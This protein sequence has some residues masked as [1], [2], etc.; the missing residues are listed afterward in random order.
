MD[1]KSNYSKIKTELPLDNLSM[2]DQSKIPVT[3]SKMNLV[4]TLPYSSVSSK[5]HKTNALNCQ[6]FH[7]PISQPIKYFNSNNSGE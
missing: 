5:F 1:K 6:V 2:A 3:Y 7:K 4:P